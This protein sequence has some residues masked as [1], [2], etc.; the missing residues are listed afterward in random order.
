MSDLRERFR[1]LDQLQPPD[2]RVDIRGRSPAEPRPEFPWRQFGTAALALTVAAVGVAFVARAFQR[3]PS[4]PSAPSE[5]N[6]RIAF[7]AQRTDVPDGIIRFD[8]CLVD[9]DG[10]QQ[11]CPVQGLPGY[12]DPAWSP[13][14]SRLVFLRA[15]GKGDGDLFIVGADGFAAERVLEGWPGRET[16]WS[17]DGTRLAYYSQQDGAIH[18]MNLDGSQDHR[19]SDSN[20]TG[21]PAWSPYGSAIAFTARDEGGAIF[22]VRPDGSGLRQVTAPPGSDFDAAWSPDGTRIAFIRT[23][24]GDAD[25]YTMRPDGTQIRRLTDDSAF[26]EDPTWSP[27]GSKIAFAKRADVGEVPQLFVMNAD[28]TGQRQL[29][30]GPAG[31]AQP[32]W[33]PVDGSQTEPTEGSPSGCPIQVPYAIAEPIQ[34]PSDIR[35]VP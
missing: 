29:T 26:D 17:P 7:M 25:V 5:P 6:A 11:E 8:L 22:V 30:Q 4:H 2:L 1:D 28:G 31:G 27:D 35:L 19:I 32:A 23:D 21:D 13:D 34:N 10:T 14:G 3:Q 9:P 15:P 20:A 24:D 33:Q 16:T 18:V 12:G